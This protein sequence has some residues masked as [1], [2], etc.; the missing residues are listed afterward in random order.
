METNR[1]TWHDYRAPGF[2]MLTLTA[3]ERDSCPFGTL[4]GES[5]EQARVVLTPLGETLKA[6][7]ESQPLRRPELELIAYVIMP[8]HCHICLRVLTPMSEHLGKVA[9]GIKYGTTCSYLDALS[10]Q[11]GRPC[12]IESTRHTHTGPVHYVR[13]LWAEGYHDRIVMRVGQVAALKRYIQRNPARLWQKRHADRSLMSVTSIF[14]PLPLPIAQSLKAFALY[15]D[16]H[17]GGRSCSP[18]QASILHVYATS[19][20]DLLGKTLRSIEVKGPS[21]SEQALPPGTPAPRQVGLRF[22]A[23]GNLELLHSGRPLVSVR[24]SRSITASQFETEIERLL[25]LCEQEGAV[26]ISPFI[27]WSEKMVLRLVRHYGYPHILVDDGAMTPF[28]KPMDAA[29]EVRVQALPAWWRGSRY[30]VMLRSSPAR[31][32]MDC[33]M[34]GQLLLLHPWHDRP[35]SDKS[36]KP[37]MELMNELCKALAQS[38]TQGG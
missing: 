34:A 36:G 26:L 30:E 16:E 12:H 1:A 2:Y 32:D 6:E 28:F 29:R 4:V 33:A 10:A 9:W 17:G 24:I 18:C 37:E 5:A 13:P 19:Y 25:A 35:V 20:V 23:C 3:E 15:C 7:I 31:T 27:S 11:Y 14:L 38:S 22:H 8:D 21:G